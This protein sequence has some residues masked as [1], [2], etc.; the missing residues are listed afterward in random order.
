MSIEQIEAIAVSQTPNGFLPPTIKS[1]KSGLRMPFGI[2]SSVMLLISALLTLFSSIIIGTPF[3]IAAITVFIVEIVNFKSAKRIQ[4]FH[5]KPIK[6]T[7]FILGFLFILCAAAI[8]LSNKNH[9][10][11]SIPDISLSLN[12]MLP[13]M[14]GDAFNQGFSNGEFILMLGGVSFIVTAICH[15]SLIRSRRHNLPFLK[16]LMVSF[17]ANVL[18]SLLC[19][20]DILNRLNIFNL[21][22]YNYSFTTNADKLIAFCQIGACIA[23]GLSVLLTAVRCLIYYVKLRRVANAVFKAKI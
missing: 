21:S 9:I 6:T 16:T 20:A 3:I 8:Y 5:I 14:I 15:A 11:L 13:F 4:N 17:I 22:Y 18:L 1:I 7:Y 12:G 19:A 23:L 10:A 2:L